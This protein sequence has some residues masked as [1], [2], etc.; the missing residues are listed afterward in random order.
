MQQAYDFA[1]FESGKPRSQ[2]E[3]AVPLRSVKG[4]KKA[5]GKLQHL[6]GSFWNLLGTVVFVALAALLIQSKA[7]ITELNAQVRRTQAELTT[8]QSTHNYLSSELNARTSMANIEEIANRLGLMKKDDSQI[9]Y[10]RLEEASVLTA[11]E[12]PVKKWTDWFH[13]GLLSL[14]D[15]LDP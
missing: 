1:V 12:S 6:L 7:T 11:E 3:Q 8:A 4:G 15:T 5:P 2:P 13:A 9:T 10:V 14:M